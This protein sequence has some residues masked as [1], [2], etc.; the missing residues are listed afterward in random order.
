MGPRGPR[1][2]GLRPRLWLLVTINESLLFCSRVL[3]FYSYNLLFDLPF[4]QRLRNFGALSWD[5]CQA[6][7]LVY[8]N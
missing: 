7:S 5:F 2:Y 6:L 1:A 4:P 3:V 8:T